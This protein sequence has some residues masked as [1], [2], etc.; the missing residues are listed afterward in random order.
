MST[1]YILTI[2]VRYHHGIKA[3]QLFSKASS[4]AN[5]QLKQDLQKLKFPTPAECNITFVSPGCMKAIWIT[6]LTSPLYRRLK[7]L[8]YRSKAPHFWD[9]EARP[10]QLDIEWIT[11]QETPVDSG[12][13]QNPGDTQSNLNSTTSGSARDS[14]I[15]G[16]KRGYS[17][18]NTIATNRELRAS[19][20]RRRASD[21]LVPSPSKRS[22]IDADGRD[23]MPD[24]ALQAG[25]TFTPQKT[26]PSNRSRPSVSTGKQR[27]NGQSGAPTPGSSSKPVRR[28]TR[29]NGSIAPSTSTSTSISEQTWT[30]KNSGEE[31]KLTDKV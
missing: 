28:S 14:S 9:S 21:G 30:D 3:T 1:P 8:V 15:Q 6:T 17:T 24:L 18:D 27:S 22:R 31:P 16:R 13:S 19:T 20:S 7:S 4:D 25:R 23:R 10:N 5:A 26:S 29:F 2:N 12:T 11:L